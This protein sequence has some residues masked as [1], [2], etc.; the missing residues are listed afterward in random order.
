MKEI[1]YAWKGIDV[2]YTIQKLWCMKT[3]QQFEER[4]LYMH[5]DRQ[6]EIHRY[7]EYA[8]FQTAEAQQI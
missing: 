3:E 7:D 5:S 2:L 1:S 8:P 6:V 4:Q